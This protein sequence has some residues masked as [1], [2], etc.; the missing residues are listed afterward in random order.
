MGTVS[1]YS[2]F[3]EQ[4]KAGGK[5]ISDS[6]AVYYCSSISWRKKQGEKRMPKL[7]TICLVLGQK[8]GGKA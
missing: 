1:V 8:I 6:S 4:K 2:F 7:H 3:T 5:A